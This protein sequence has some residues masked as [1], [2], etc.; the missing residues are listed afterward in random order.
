MFFARLEEQGRASLAVARERNYF[1]AAERVDWLKSLWP[2][3]RFAPA[4]SSVS[5]TV[6]DTDEVLR[7]GVQGWM[8]ILGPVS[9]R[10]LAQRLGVSPSEVWKQMLRL[11]MSGTILRGVFEGVGSVDSFADEDVEWCERRLLQ[12]IHKRTL[13]ALRKQ[14]E[15]VTPS[16]FMQWLLRWQQVAPNTQL[17]GEAGVLGGAAWAGGV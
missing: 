10:S 13:V 4:V 8:Q 5:V 7:K 6:T 1:C 14:V 9:S 16:T 15:P 11:E 17:A 12:R 2:E 3:V